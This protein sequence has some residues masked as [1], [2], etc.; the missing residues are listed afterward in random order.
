VHKN[1]RSSTVKTV[2][3]SDVSLRNY[4]EKMEEIRVD[5]RMCACVSLRQLLS[6]VTSKLRRSFYAITN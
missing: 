5:V 6:V 4:R 1:I 3:E 2:F